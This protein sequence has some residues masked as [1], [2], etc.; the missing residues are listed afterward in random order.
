MDSTSDKQEALLL[1]R[2]RD[3]AEFVRRRKTARF[4]GF[5]D[6]RQR[7]LAEPVVR[8][9]G[10]SY[11]FEGGYADAQRTMLGIFP[12]ANEDDTPFPFCALGFSYR[13]EAKLTHRDFL[14]TLLGTGVRREAIGDILCGEGLS[15]AFVTEELLPFL[16]T[17]TERVGREG[18]R[19]LPHYDGELPAAFHT[20]P[21]ERTVASARLDCVLAAL[22]GLSREEA[23]RRIREG[24]VSVD[25]RPCE[26]VGRLLSGGAVLSVRGV[27]RFV[28]DEVETP[29]RKG[30]LI[31][32]ARKYV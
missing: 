28:I 22:V 31:L 17:Q 19:L 9:T 21:V 18:V 7:A 8:R 14:G 11:R 1:A 13:R 3:T 24:L 32:K 15:V 2:V 30:R 16:T 25:H 20:E 10:L 23:S 29:T 27:G 12:S 5:L 26:T 4:I 6:E